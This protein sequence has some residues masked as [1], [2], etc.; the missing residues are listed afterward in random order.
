MNSIF[1][2]VYWGAWPA[3]NLVGGYVGSLVGSR[4]TIFIGGLLFACLSLVFLVGP[5]R[6][7]SL[8]VSAAEA[9]IEPA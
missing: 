5:L 3:G 7:A 6:R 8:N 9:K 4:T 1:R 2:T